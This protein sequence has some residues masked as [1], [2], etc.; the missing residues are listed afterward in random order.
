M[1]VELL[2]FMDGSP[3]PPDFPE[4]RIQLAH[5]L[6][7]RSAAIEEA[8]F[9]RVRALSEPAGERDADYVDGLHAAVVETIDYALTS[10]EEGEAWAGP[11]PP[12]VSAQ[13]QRAARSGVSLETVL[14]RYVAGDRLLKEFI[15]DVARELPNPAL[16]RILSTQ[17]P[18]FDRF[19]GLV[20]VDYMHEHERLMRFPGQRITERVQQLLAGT[21][22]DKLD[23]LAYELSAWHL[24]LIAHGEK[25]E[26][27]V[28][29]LA[30][31]LDRQILVVPQ[32]AGTVWAWFG[33]RRQIR[34]AD[35]ERQLKSSGPRGV[36]LAVGEP[37][38]GIEGWRLTH[39]EAR[40]AAQVMQHRPE[41][42]TRASEV[43][44]I[45][46]VLENEALTESLLETYL[47]PL[48]RV[49]DSG[50]VLRQTLRAYFEADC[51]AATAAAALQVN[52]HT[53]RRRLQK[54]EQALGRLL[55][56]CRAELEVA[57]RIEELR[58]APPRHR[59]TP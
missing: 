7:T 1:L 20:T 14:R 17:I 52:R 28:R 54:I 8:I 15:M 57:L 4:L 49:S 39:H 51:N 3:G 26:G 38:E 12:A 16:R 27:L 29:A 59:P 31:A 11:L 33:G 34:V 41:R 22:S 42:L 2:G 50:E 45:A 40:A 24:G 46:A 5:K 23:D 47:A 53:V 21:E 35:I 56:V 55:N 30:A 10:I 48:D 44:L 9:A 13:A 6:R 25:A 43:L 36:T 37:R 58:I 32:D 18:A 19:V